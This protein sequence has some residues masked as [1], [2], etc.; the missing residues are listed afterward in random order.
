MPPLEAV[1]RAARLG[2]GA[3]VLWVDLPTGPAALWS[4]LAR[5]LDV[6][7]LGLKG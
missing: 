7:V 3:T 2:I 4:A 5:E 6:A 1:E